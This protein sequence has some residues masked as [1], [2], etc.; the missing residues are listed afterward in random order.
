MH[1]LVRGTISCSFPVHILSYVR[2]F[3]RRRVSWGLLCGPD[4]CS[5]LTIN[6]RVQRGSWQLFVISNSRPTSKS[7][8]RSILFVKLLQSFIESTLL[9]CWI[10]RLIVNTT[11]VYHHHHH[12]PLFHHNWHMV[13]NP[14]LIQLNL[15][16]DVLCYRLFALIHC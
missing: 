7:R 16:S 8:Q 1:G 2:S 9:S 10:T 14:F 6:P 12:N 13:F 11:T 5:L 15:F 3:T 4:W